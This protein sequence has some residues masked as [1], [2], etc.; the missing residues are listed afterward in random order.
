MKV[1]IVDDSK[2]ARDMAQ[3]LLEPHMD[4]CHFA[5]NG[6]EA[7]DQA[8]KAFMEGDPFDLICLDIEMPVM[9]GQ[10]ALKMI[11]MLE[12]ESINP[13]E[14]PT[15]IWM[16]T[17]QDTSEQKIKAI[18]HGGCNGFIVKSRIKDEL[19]AKLKD[20]GLFRNIRS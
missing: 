9:D 11:R 12:R 10:Q 2:S 1:L 7:V 4:A 5:T 6:Q 14:K 19:I 8:R 3:Q 13:T 15:I 16:I 20:H 18:F 17:S